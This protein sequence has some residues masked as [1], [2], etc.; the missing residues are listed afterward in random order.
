MFYIIEDWN[1]E[2]HKVS[3]DLFLYTVYLSSSVVYPVLGHM[4][5]YGLIH[6]LIS[7]PSPF[8]KQSSPSGPDSSEGEMGEKRHVGWLVSCPTESKASAPL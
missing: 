8:T 6:W 3:F 2:Y 5:Q 7:L 4:G 1:K